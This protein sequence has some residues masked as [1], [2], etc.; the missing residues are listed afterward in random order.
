[1]YRLR[2]LAREDIEIINRWRNNPELI[3][4]LGAPYRYIDISIDEMWYEGYLQNRDKEVRCSIIDDE[5]TLIG[6]I[7]L[8]SIDSIRQSACLNIMIGDREKRGKGAGTYAIREMLNHGFYNLNLR[9]I[10]LLVLEENMVARHLYEK[11][12]FVQEGIM[13]DANYKAGK[14]VNMVMYSILKDEYI[15]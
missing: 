1:M 3:Q 7:S 13:R 15:K 11:I 8:V 14:F 5:N 4:L 9:R 10:E 6:T 12:G 2:E